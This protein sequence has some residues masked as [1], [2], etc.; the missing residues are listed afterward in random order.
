MSDAAARPDNWL[1]E[2]DWD[3]MLPDTIDKASAHKHWLEIV[4]ELRAQAKLASV[5]GHAVSRLVIARV[6]YEQAARLVMREGLTITHKNGAVSQHPALS[7]QNKQAEICAQL[8]AELTLSPR[9]RAT[10]GKVAGKR[11]DEGGGVK[12]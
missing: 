3:G 6:M 4:G 1:A 5:N 7:I 12:L 10:G 8:E 11:K 9:K 2:P